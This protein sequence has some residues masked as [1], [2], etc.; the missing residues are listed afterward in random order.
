MTDSLA[1]NLNEWVEEVEAEAGAEASGRKGNPRRN[2]C[3][4]AAL[5]LV[6]TLAVYPCLG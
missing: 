1:R 4:I 3:D 6:H 2:A 5:A